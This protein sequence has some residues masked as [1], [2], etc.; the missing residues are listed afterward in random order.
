M[1][2]EPVTK[3]IDEG[4]ARLISRYKNKPRFAAWCASWIR[5]S[6]DFEDACWELLSVLDVDTA[7]LPRLTKLGKIVGQPPHGTL[8]QFRGYVKV[9]VLVNRSKANAPSLIKIA[10]IL[11]GN[12]T[13]TRWGRGAITITADEI[14]TAFDGDYVGFLLNLAKGGGVRLQLVWTDGPATDAFEFAPGTSS[15]ADGR[16]FANAAETVG[17]KLAR[18]R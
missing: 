6:Q 4:L 13:Y 5:Q 10:R 1:A 2:I 7:D 12:V 3:H 14:L 15:I 8:E 9:R 11:M 18:I 16:G 17:G